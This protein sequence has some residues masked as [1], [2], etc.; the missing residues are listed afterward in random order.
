MATCPTCGSDLTGQYCNTCGARAPEERAPRKKKEAASPAN[1]AHHP[2]RGPGLLAPTRIWRTVAVVVLGL[3]IYGGGIFTGIYMAQGGTGSGGLATT[4][5]NIGDPAIDT[6]PPLARATFYMEKGVSLMNEGQ[7]SAAVSEFRKALKE[8]QAA[9]EQE[10]ENLYAQTYLGLTYYYAGDSQRAVEALRAVLEKDTY[11]LW[12]IF[13][14]GW[15]YET[16]GKKTEA[17]LMY[18]KYLAVAPEEKKNML[19][20]AEQFELIDRQV[21]AAQT[22]VQ[23]LQ[24]GGSGQ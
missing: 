9:I 4:L 7:R 16:G 15:I 18:N 10:P 17:V 23:R 13:N 1:R 11:Y 22:A 6:M 19:K 8:W 20:Y 21:E 3:V 12:A 14:L 2:G 5:S 24:G